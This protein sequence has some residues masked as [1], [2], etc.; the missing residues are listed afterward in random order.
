[1]EIPADK[2][3]RMRA[4]STGEGIIAALA[5]DQRKSLRKPIAAIRGVALESV[6]DDMLAEF[7]AAVARI[8]SPYASAVLLDPDYGLPA[9]TGLARGTGLLLAYEA[10]GFENP[11]PNR[12]LALS[13]S[14]SVRR[15]KECG[16][17]GVKILLSY[18]PF[19]D[20]GV[21]DEKHVMVERIGDECAG[22]GI[23]FFLEFVGYDAQGGDENSIE[24]ARIKPEI[25]IRS[26]TEFS[27]AI[28]KVDVMKVQIP[29][30]AAFV[31]GSCVYK[32]Q[33]AYSYDE[34]LELLQR[35]AAAAGKPFIY[36]SAAVGIEEFTES[37]QMAAEAGAA[38]SGVLCGRATWRDGIPVY[39]KHGLSA[40]ED[41]L[42]NAGV[43][44]IKA[45]NEAIRDA[46][47]WWGSGAHLDTVSEG[48]LH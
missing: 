10:D 34:A 16:A 22:A 47:P 37:L 19:D 3:G 33:K 15:M 38:F 43:R 5:I 36:L 29:V 6:T 20:P 25:V 46:T 11:R 48:S 32:G 18:T 14:L 7:K 8:L 28:Y 17:S 13:P 40:L 12:M 42:Q 41:W 39:A 30:N 26:M 27:K 24:Y 1:L 44:N 31:E 4:L 23:P 9:I 45:V 2:I 21:N 35:A